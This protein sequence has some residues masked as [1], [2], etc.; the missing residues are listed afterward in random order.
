MAEP[1]KTPRTRSPFPGM[2]PY[3]EQYWGDVHHRLCTYACDLHRRKLPEGLVPRLDERTVIEDDDAEER[4]II[5]DVRVIQRGK[6]E[7]GSVALLESLP[8]TEPPVIE[9]QHEPVTEGFIQVIDT[10]NGGK[11]VT[12]IEFTSPAN[13]LAGMGRKMYRRKS[14]ELIAGK[15][16]LVEVDLIRAG[17]WNL[18][19]PQRMVAARHRDGT[20]HVCVTRGWNRFQYEVYPI[21]LR[22]RLP[23]ISVPL[24]KT[25]PDA[26]LDL[27]SLIDQAYENGSYGYDVD[28]IKPPVPALAEI[29]RDWEKSL[30]M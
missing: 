8:A 14:K 6:S 2:D 7:P 10:R 25:D 20:Y 27:Q 17:K 30:L 24:R 16:S 23:V 13:K 18:R 3:L 22:E 21:T 11:I 19:A 5:P 9:I 29:D 15:V 1:Q 26:L 12:V 28:Y 4:T